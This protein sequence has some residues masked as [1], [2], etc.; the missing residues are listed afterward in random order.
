MDKITDK[1][2]R[3]LRTEAGAA[4][5]D[6]MVAICDLALCGDDV[7]LRIC[8]RAIRAAKEAAR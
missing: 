3:E 4:G 1:Q 5:D 7:A 8:E 6:E 2:I